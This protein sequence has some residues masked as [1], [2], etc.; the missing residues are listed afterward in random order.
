MPVLKPALPEEPLAEEAAA[1]AA[2]AKLE[3][4]AN[5]SHELRTPVH[6]ILSFARI[7]ASRA[8]TTSPE[9]LRDYFEHIH[10]S[11]ERLLDLVNDL[12]DLSKLEA[13]C[14]KYMMERLDLARR[15]MDVVTELAP[16]IESKQLTCTLDRSVA[17]SHI[18]GDHKRIDQ[19]LRNLLG[20][21]IKFTPAGRRI[22]IEIAADVMP[23][24][25]RAMDDRVQPALR[26][27]VADEGIGIP[28]T[29]VESVF[30][31]FTQSSLTSTGAG[32]TGLG[33]P[34]CREIVHAHRGLIR[35][36]NRPEGGAAFD[37][38]LPLVTGIQP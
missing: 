9:K 21:A 23:V 31:K 37:V 26:L 1:Q 27:T 3:F 4:L 10:A 35:A 36:R 13:G 16:L 25:R 24:G 12:L 18:S 32:G 19:V 30:D 7:G 20:N 38:L 14:M 2:E 6:A 5:M 17:D 8:L 22:A 33:L 11:G 29:E 15:A 28:E 34:I